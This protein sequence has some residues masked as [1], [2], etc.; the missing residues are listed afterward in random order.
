M[1]I[2]DSFPNRCSLILLPLIFATIITSVYG[3]CEH[4][5][6]QDNKVYNYSLAKPIRNFPHGILSEDGYSPFLFLLAHVL[7]CLLILWYLWY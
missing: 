3:T 5:F 4:S 7:K 6:E 2:G 1:T